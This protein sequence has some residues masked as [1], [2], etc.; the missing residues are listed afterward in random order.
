VYEDK[1]NDPAFHPLNLGRTDVVLKTF[2]KANSYQ[3]HPSNPSFRQ[4]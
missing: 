4:Q 1:S 3:L 2:E